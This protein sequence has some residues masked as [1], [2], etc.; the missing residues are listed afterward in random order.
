MFNPNKKSSAPKP[1]TKEDLLKE[2]QTLALATEQN[3][4]NPTDIILSGLK[5]V[6]S[7]FPKKK[8]R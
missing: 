7:K 8:I 5:I 3:G 2:I 1:K 6:D 4:G